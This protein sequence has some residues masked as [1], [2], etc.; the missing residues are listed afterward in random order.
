MIQ[1]PAF[2]ATFCTLSAK[3][4]IHE[5]AE[6]RIDDSHVPFSFFRVRQ[7]NRLRDLSRMIS[8]SS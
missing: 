4:L 7:S 8:G 3:S 6:P 1:L 2:C 5:K